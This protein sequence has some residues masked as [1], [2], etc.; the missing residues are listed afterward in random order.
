VGSGEWNEAAGDVNH[1]TCWDGFDI[2]GMDGVELIC[3][4]NKN[5][6]CP[7]F[8]VDEAGDGVLFGS[9]GRD[10]LSDSD[11]QQFFMLGMVRCADDVAVKLALTRLRKDL[12]KNPLYSSIPSM[13]PN[14]RKTAR[15]FHAK[16][17]HP[18]VRAKVFE[19]LTHLDFRI[20]AVIKDMR[21][22]R[23]YV[24]NR[25]RMHATY[26]Y[27][28][29][30]LYDLTVRMLF[31][32][33][34]HKHDAYRITFARRGKS[35]RTLTLSNELEKTRLSFLAEQKKNHT[36][37]IEIRP[38]YPWE[39]PCLQVADYC[40][41]ALQRCYERHESRFIRALWSKVS[42]IH[43]VDDPLGKSYGTYLSRKAE[44][45]NLEKIKNRWI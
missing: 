34:L 31:K 9:K 33:R 29:N 28:P 42:L 40:L 41:W 44:P 18:E 17:D 12:L 10:R 14:A 7:T 20:Y 26:R 6:K 35:D 27:T 5:Q 37:E 25:N 15:A 38:A 11:A 32:Q 36:P 2:T 24:Q 1:T 23:L 39:E 21:A 30:E 22:V 43:D 13:Q 19:C 3:M 4:E 8:Y 16:D 45:P